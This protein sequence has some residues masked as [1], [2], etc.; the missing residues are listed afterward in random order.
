MGAVQQKAK[1]PTG[2]YIHCYIWTVDTGG[3]KYM[4]VGGRRL[5]C[6][7][8]K[9]EIEEGENRRLEWLVVNGFALRGDGWVK[10]K[11]R[12]VPSS[13]LHGME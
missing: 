1:Y 13:H 6:A 5:A 11:W 3:N 10:M 2:S 9:D 8:S 4:C 7:W 12:G